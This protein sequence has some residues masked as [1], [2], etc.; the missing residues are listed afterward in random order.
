[1]K[2]LTAVGVALAIL[3]AAGDAAAGLYWQHD[4]R[5]S[6]ISYCFVGDALT[7]RPGRVAEIRDHLNDFALHANIRFNYLGTCPASV[8]SGG[9]DWF[10]GDIRV[11][12]PSTSVSGTGMVPGTGCPAFGGAAAYNGDNDGWGSWSNAP[13]DL[14]SYRPCLYNLKLGD[15]PW[16]A[17]PY[18]NHTLHE[19]GHALG[20][21]HEHARADATCPAPGGISVGY[22][23]PYDKQSVMHYQY[24]SCGVD[25][26]YGQS[27]LSGY[28]R[29]S[30][31]ILYPEAGLPAQ[32][33]GLK[34][35]EVRATAFLQF[36][37]RYEGAHMPFVASSV[38]WRL[39]G[40]LVSTAVDFQR[41]MD[42]PGTYTVALTVTD[43]LGRVHSGS[44]TLRV[45]SNAE[46]VGLQGSL[47]AVSMMLNSV[48]P[49]QVFKSGFELGEVAQ[50]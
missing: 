1:M 2:R 37:W 35:I 45:L 26:N 48:Q 14:A 50:Y 8:P 25:G 29:L 11:V 31:R 21:S 24:L 9:K 27:G 28:D 38:Q 18:R 16:N 7:S 34:V 32:I 43:F 47:A 5:S 15:D 19:F 41:V 42:T 4:V 39:D 17:T 33:V 44:S 10:G 6:P 40:T 23:T 12:I 36:G 13:D 22:L 30:L 49:L 46:F 20:L 3:L